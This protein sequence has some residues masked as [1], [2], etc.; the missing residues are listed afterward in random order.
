MRTTDLSD[1]CVIYTALFWIVP[2][3]LLVTAALGD[4][5]CNLRILSNYW[6]RPNVREALALV[7]THVFAW[8]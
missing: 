8:W 1:R 5:Q 4:V 6:S 3:T 2:S 7:L